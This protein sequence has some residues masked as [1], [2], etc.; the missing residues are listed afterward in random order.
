MSG[1]TRKSVEPIALQFAR[2]PQGAAATQNEVVALAHLYVTLTKRD[3]KRDVPE[4]TLD[5]ALRLLRSAF[6][7]PTLSEQEAI[8]LV[9]YH[10][11][12]NRVAHDS[13]RKTWLQKHKQLARKLLL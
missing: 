5:T 7:K 11:E 4:L 2:G 1:Q 10:L 12:R 13:H 9:D 8:D 6:A 3:M